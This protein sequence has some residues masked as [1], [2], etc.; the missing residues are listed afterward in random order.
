M[1]GQRKK[2]CCD[3]RG[4][5]R[6]SGAR[7]CSYSSQVCSGDSGAGAGR[8]SCGCGARRRH[9]AD[10]DA[11]AIGKAE[12]VHWRAARDRCRDARGGADG[13]GRHGQ[14]ESCGRGSGCGYA[15]GG[16]LR[17]RWHDVSGAA[18]T[19]SR[20]RHGIRWRDLFCGA[21]LDRSAMAAGR[22]S[23]SCIAGAGSGRR[24]LQ[25]ECRRNGGG[26][27]RGLPRERAHL[28]DRRTGSERC[29][30]SG[31]SVVEH[32]AGAGHGGGIDRERRHAAETRSLQTG[33]EAGSRQG[34]DTARGGSG[35]AAAVLSDEVEL[36]N[37]SD[38]RLR[39]GIMSAGMKLQKEESKLN[40]PLQSRMPAA[41][42][43]FPGIF[44]CPD[45]VSTRDLGPQGVEA[46]LHLAELM[47]SRPSVF[48]RSLA[49]KQMVMFFE[50][51]S[52]RTRL[53]FEA[54]MAGLGG[55]AMFVDQSQ[56][57]LD[58]R[59]TL[60][61]IAHNLERWVD[62]IVL[63]TFAQETIAGMARYAS[64]PVI[65]AL[66]DLE[67]PC[68][69]LAD[70]FT[71]QERFGDLKNITLA[72]V[73]DGNNVA[74]SLLLTCACLG[75]SIR[76]ATP[77]GYSPNAQIVADARKIAKQTGAQIELLADPH[78]AVAG[79]DAVYTD[80]WASMGQEN[81]AGQ[82]GEIFPPYQVNVELMA[83]AAPH[84]AFMHCLPAHRGEEVT[85]EVMDSDNSVIFEQAENRLHVQKSILYLL[86]GGAVRL[87]VRSAHA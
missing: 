14:Q 61:D 74:H 11:E 51:P 44:W 30:G 81:E 8:S 49:G 82:R 54:G 20:Q 56:S 80:A 50:K 29:R 2:V 16:I 76:I 69:A 60:S 63:R 67:H 86:L 77:K 3:Y 5:N 72:Y 9:C 42:E 40:S 45:L 15:G 41:P 39:L 22:D 4:Q 32:Q 26:L 28:P 47:K 75:S 52:L 78:A 27:R 25:R 73:G 31:D 43:T 59:E 7:G 18:K 83:E 35:S 87:P 1:A 38:L 17:R 21:V 58:A 19:H 48:Q 71:L 12:R 10:P 24:V 85:D 53:T 23:G 55:T 64:V 34:A 57:R 37:R 70:Y 79:V 13:A 68:Q 33:V 6:R 84:A 66:S 62:V 46:V 36:W 65:N